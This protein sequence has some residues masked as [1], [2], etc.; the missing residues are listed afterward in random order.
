MRKRTFVV[1]VAATKTI[2]TR[3]EGD[4]GEQCHD[5]IRPKLQCWR[6]TAGF[7]I[8]LLEARVSVD[9]AQAAGGLLQHRVLAGEGEELLGL[10]LAGQRP[11]ARA[12]AAG[13]DDG[14][15]HDADLPSKLWIIAPHNSGSPLDK[16]NRGIRADGLR[17]SRKQ[18]LRASNFSHSRALRR[19][20]LR[21]PT[22]VTA[23]TDE[24]D[25]CSV[26]ASVV[27]RV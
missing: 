22:I 20:R 26:R 10:V 18:E 11:K 27:F 5:E 17:S 8:S 4:S 12:G 19:M 13:E 7:C 21:I 16:S 9:S 1:A 24:R 14:S 23:H 2:R 6:G 3:C 15:E 25:R